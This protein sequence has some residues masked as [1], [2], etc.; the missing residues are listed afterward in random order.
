MAN[1]CSNIVIFKGEAILL[2]RVKFLFDQLAKKE[3]TENKGQL[4]DFIK[5]DDGYFFEIWTLANILNYETRWSPNTD[6]LKQVADHFGIGFFY[7]YVE[8]MNGIHGK[9]NYHNGVLT[10]TDRN[11]KHKT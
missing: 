9:I 8:P 5:A 11:L 3:K 6:V 7:E 1:W 2:N 10:Q 4:P